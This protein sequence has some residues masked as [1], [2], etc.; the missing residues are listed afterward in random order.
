MAVHPIK[1]FVALYFPYRFHILLRTL[2]FFFTVFTASWILLPLYSNLCPPHCQLT[3]MAKSQSK[4]V[5]KS[6]PLRSKSSQSKDPAF[7]TPTKASVLKNTS[8]TE[9]TPST[10]SSNIC[11]ICMGVEAMMS[12][13]LNEALQE[14]TSRIDEYKLLTKSLQEN[15][16]TLN[17]SMDTIKHFI[18]AF[19][20]VEAE[21]SLRKID[22][23]IDLLNNKLNNLSD[24]IMKLSPNITENPMSKIAT[25]I[26]VLDGKINGLSNYAC[27]IDSIEKYLSDRRP[28]S[29]TI[30]TSSI[31][32][33]DK[34]NQRLSHLE[35]LC[36]Q[37]NCKIDTLSNIPAPSPVDH[38]NSTSSHPNNNSP[39]HHNPNT[40]I[41]LGDSNTKYVNINM[42]KFHNTTRVPTFTISDI[43]P[44]KCI[45][46][47]KIWLHVGINNLK[48]YNCSRDADVHNHFQHFMNKLKAIQRLCPSSRIIISPIL[49]TDVPE[50]NHR[51]LIFNRLLFSIRENVTF[52]DFNSFCGRNGRLLKIYKCYNNLH[53][54][55][56]L[57]ALGIRILG[58]KLIS[59]LSQIDTRSYATV[60]R[61]NLR[62]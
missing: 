28:L 52:L 36:N 32:S 21:S 20:P 34:I 2:F 11:S 13:K 17:H 33:N 45:G 50:L 23:N 30:D 39:S 41:I 12:L 43:D 57:G 15:T 24:V 16:S 49:P 46:Y 47:S 42:H 18:L 38:L 31:N 7:I 58:T 56:H 60:L 14:F 29:H 53:D 22:T 40:C 44:T 37:L 59:A 25:S 3:L 26:D 55:I 9:S 48:S 1:K 5:S 27:K 35:S 61:N 62:D 51:A 4:N 6:Y 54:N 10:P 8:K 19:E